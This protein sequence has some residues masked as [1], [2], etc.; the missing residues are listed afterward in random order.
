MTRIEE[1][2][3]SEGSPEENRLSC[4]ILRLLSDSTGVDFLHYKHSTLLRRI[5]RRMVLRRI[6]SLADYLQWLRDDAAER[7]LLFEEV[8]IPVTSFFREPE[9]YEALKT[10]ILPRLLA[11]RPPGTPF[12]VWVP[13]CATRRGSLFHRHLPAGVPGQPRRR[14]S[15]SRSSP[16]TSASA[17]SRRP[18][19]ASTARGS[20][21]M[22]PPS[23]SSAS[24]SRPTGAMRSASGARPVHLRPAGPD[25]GPALLAA[26]SHQSAA[27]S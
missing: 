15:R 2:S 9:S 17:P 13:G 19:P 1:A 7:Q 8:L 6:Q 24:S 12:R 18:G 27:T 11:G 10:T 23:G 22:S 4:E 20:R 16:P 25:Q 21:P 3:P 5:E 14:Q 26:R